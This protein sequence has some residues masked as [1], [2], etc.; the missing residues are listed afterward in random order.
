MRKQSTYEN[1]HI[2]HR[3]LDGL[4]HHDVASNDTEML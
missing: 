4:A 1:N 2:Y 3:H